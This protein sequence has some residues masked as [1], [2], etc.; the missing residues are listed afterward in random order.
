MTC[1]LLRPCGG[2]R[3]QQSFIQP[4]KRPVTML[5][6]SLPSAN[7]MIVITIPSPTISWPKSGIYLV[8]NVLRVATG[9]T[10]SFRVD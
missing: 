9:R 6:A 3:P 2:T 10:A 1:P 8:D 5:T 7:A 4:W